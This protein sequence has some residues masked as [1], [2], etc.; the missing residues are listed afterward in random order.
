MAFTVLKDRTDITK[1]EIQISKFLFNIK[2]KFLFIFVSIWVICKRTAN[3]LKTTCW[4][5]FQVSSSSVHPHFMEFLRGLGWTVN[6][7]QH[8]GWTGHVSTAFT[9]TPQP[10]EG[11]ILIVVFCTLPKYFLHFSYLYITISFIDATVSYSNWIGSPIHFSTCSGQKQKMS[12]QQSI[13]LNKYYFS[14]WLL[15]MFA[16]SL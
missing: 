13:M 16:P 11:T 14:C 2:N 3:I 6:V 15:S 4:V 1:K 8:P 7:Q 9:I 10:Q 5:S 12:S